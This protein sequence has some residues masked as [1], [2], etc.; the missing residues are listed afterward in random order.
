MTEKDGRPGRVGRPEKPLDPGSGPVAAFAYALREL[1]HSAGEPTYAALAKR[2]GV[3]PSAL[4]EAARGRRLAS[5]P[6]VEAFVRGCGADPLPWRERW[7]AAGGGAQAAGEFLAAG[8]ASQAAGG[9]QGDDQSGR[10]RSRWLRHRTLAVGGAPA[11]VLL[12]SVMIY[13]RM[14]H[15]P[16]SHAP[17]A[18]ASRSPAASVLTW[19]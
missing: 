18:H 12:A 4:S 17:A 8:G 15:A 9:A 7:D 14:P 6:T 1:R 5:W 3:S 11:L 19:T 2:T 16:V 13:A 10:S